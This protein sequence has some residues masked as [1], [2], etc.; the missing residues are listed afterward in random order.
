MARYEGP[1]P[2]D[3][4]F[5]E[6][7]AGGLVAPKRSLTRKRASWALD[8]G[9][10]L[11]RCRINYNVMHADMD[12]NL[13]RA[14][15][16]HEEGHLTSAGTTKVWSKIS[17]MGAIVFS[18]LVSASFASLGVYVTALLMVPLFFGT[19]NFSERMFRA[20]RCREETKADL[21]AA[22]V[23]ITEFAIDKPSVVFGTLFRALRARPRDRTLVIH[24]VKKLLK[25]ESHPSD[26]ERIKAIQELEESL[27]KGVGV[28][29]DGLH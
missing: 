16:L 13:L 18:V 1:N 4:V 8:F 7:K 17:L 20:A 24:R 25:V 22:R 28:Y 6:L 11:V 5:A 19:L 3:L 21:H 15:L 26:E 14:A 10:D 23:L 12:A 2:I 9:S 29:G 27:A